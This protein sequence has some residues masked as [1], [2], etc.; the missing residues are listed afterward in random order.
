M[1]N[2]TQEQTAEPTAEEPPK[3]K[4]NLFKILVEKPIYSL[5][6]VLTVLMLPAIVYLGYDLASAQL[7]PCDKIYQQS[8][9]GLTTKIKFLEAEGE[10]QIGKRKL[11]ELDDRARAVALNL[12]TCC[13]V[14]DA[15]KLDP[16]QFLQCKAK[17]RD[18]DDRIDQLVALVKQAVAKPDTPAPAKVAAAGADPVVTGTAKANPQLIQAAITK[19]VE[20]AKDVSKEFNTQVVQVSKEQAVERLK[21]VPPQNVQVKAGEREPNNDILNTNQ[22]ELGAWITGAVADKGDWDY[23]VFTTPPDHRD[24]I[25]IEVQNRS[26]SL[27]PR[28]IVYNADKAEVGSTYNGTSGGDAKYSFVVGP[29]QKFY[30]AVGDR[31]GELK[32]VYLFKVTATKSYDKFEPNQDVLKA[33][34]ASFGSAIEASIMDGRDWDFFVI[35]TGGAK[36]KVR[37]SLE[38][39]SL[40]LKPKLVLYNASKAYV[41]EQ[42]NNTPGADLEYGFDMPAGKKFYIAVASRYSA[43]SGDYTLTVEKE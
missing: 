25:T 17:G 7:N 40:S 35:Q 37:V 4:W 10:I 27:R 43:T 3:K 41:G 15:G 34:K 23:Y 14:L 22:V 28:I 29:E 36:G 42:S 1:M 9:L 33:S 16:E 2:Q 38:N 20:K 19:T 8:S 5:G 6:I 30:A 18:Y 39:R 13:T 24:W 26:T 31:Y 11:E 12:K 32:G 21:A